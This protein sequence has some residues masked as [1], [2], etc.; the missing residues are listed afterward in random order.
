MTDD[1][2][3]FAEQ[4]PPV[5]VAGSRRIT[6]QRFVATLKGTEDEIWS[7]L[8]QFRAKAMLMEVSAW[9]KL[10]EDLKAEPAHP[11]HPDWPGRS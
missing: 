5:D 11:H 10:I 3:P 2:N 1:Q 4:K 6:L 8:L 7:K 9:R